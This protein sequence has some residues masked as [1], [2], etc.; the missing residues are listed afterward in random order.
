MKRGLTSPMWPF[1][2]MIVV[3]LIAAVLGK[4]IHLI[5]RMH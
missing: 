2:V 5:F 1:T 4:F 3:L